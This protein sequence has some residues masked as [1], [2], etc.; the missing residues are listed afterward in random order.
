MCAKRTVADVSAVADPSTGVYVYTTYGGDPGFMVFGGTSA[1]SPIIAATYALA[2]NPSSKNAVNSYPYANAG[3]LHDVTSGSNGSCGGSYLCTAGVGYDGPTGLGTPNG[4]GAFSAT[5]QPDFTLSAFPASL[6]V[7]PGA[8]GTTTMT[9][10]SV[11]TFSGSVALSASVAPATGLTAAFSPSSVT[12][13][14]SVT[15]TLT[16]TADPLA[17]GPYTVTVTGTGPGGLMHSA[18]VNV[19][20]SAPDFSMSASPAS[21]IIPAGGT[22]SSSIAVN[23]LVGFTGSVDLTTGVAPATGLNASVSPSSVTL[24]ASATSTLSLTAGPG[25]SGTFAVTVT[26]TSGALVHSTVVNVTVV[27][28]D[29]KISIAPFTFAAPR[30][31][32]GSFTVTVTSLSGFTGPVQLKV[33][34]QKPGD[35]V[36]YAVNPILGG[37]GSAT[38]KI[39]P[40]WSDSPGM[41]PLIVTGTSNGLSHTAG[42]L[43]T[44]S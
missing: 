1:S 3:A 25:V 36:T 13:A 21:L 32:G 22:G 34:G 16:L 38:V 30:G 39:T 44:I 9:L 18:T 6:A 5:Q 26:G 37:S 8:S 35:V 11:G 14:G 27:A 10:N 7:A 20:V 2:G 23:A 4:T 28:Q 42:A 43:M 17:S 19:L 33:T 24:G 15:S 31:V 12:V 41:V 29:F 40:S